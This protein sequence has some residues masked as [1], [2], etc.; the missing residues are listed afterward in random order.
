MIYK[1]LL[2][3]F[4]KPLAAPTKR[5]KE[6]VEKLRSTFRELPYLETKYY[7]THSSAEAW[8]SNIKRLRELV[9]NNDPREFL[10]WDVIWRTM[11]VENSE[12]VS[13]ELNF[14]TN[15]LDWRRRWCKAIKESSI[16]HPM[17]YLRYPRSSGN[18]IHHA[19][20]LAQFEHKTGMKVDNFNCIFEF[21][22]G[23]GSMCRLFYNLKYRGQYVIFDFPA[24]SALQQFFLNSIG[25]TVHSIDL[26]KTKKSGIVCISD[27][28]KLEKI[29]SNYIEANNA[30]FIATWSI[31]ETPVS[32][33][34]S[35]LSLVTKF[36]AFLI[37]Y[38][39]RFAE[40]NNIK[41]FMNWR[42]AQKNIEFHNWQIE[43]LTNNYYL[44][45]TRK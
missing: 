44:F 45:G 35:I 13:T 43:H 23:Y 36:K 2:F 22:G 34:D 7:S 11:F 32:Y 31:S 16:G 25:M 9:L 5:E 14:L 1:L 8:L 4:D 10:R 39:G 40:V 41:Y 17:P 33:R 18:L 38:Q 12:Y 6:L 30:M 24:F 26:F 21:G 19:Y 15:L 29:I 27:I 20:H 42:D 28:E 3:V 37:S